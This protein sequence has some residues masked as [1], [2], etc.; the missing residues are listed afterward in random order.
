MLLSAI[1]EEATGMTAVEFGKLTLFEPLGISQYQWGSYADGHTH[2]DGG[3][4]LRPRDMAKIG[5]LML[6][7]GQWNGIQIVQ[8]ALV[9]LVPAFCR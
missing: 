7:N 8:S 5:Q 2:T 9:E 3:L 4:S 6:N 1:L